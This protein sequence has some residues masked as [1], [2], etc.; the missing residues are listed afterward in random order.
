MT[1]ATNRSRQL[2]N[3]YP[4]IYDKDQEKKRKELV[5]IENSQVIKMR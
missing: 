1:I 4:Q 5:L 3:T 2:M